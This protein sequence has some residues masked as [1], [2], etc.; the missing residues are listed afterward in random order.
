MALRELVTYLRY[1]VDNSGLKQYVKEADKAADDVSKA[2]K[3]TQPT[4]GGATPRVGPQG[5]KIVN[6]PGQ[7]PGFFDT[8]PGKTPRFIPLNTTVPG[9]TPG[10]S[11]FSIPNPNQVALAE[12]GAQ[13]QKMRDAEREA[14]A[15][16][17][18]QQQI[19]MAERSAQRQAARQAEVNAR[20]Q[21]RAEERERRNTA[22]AEATAART[23]A[24]QEAAAARVAERERRGAVAGGGGAARGFFGGIGGIVGPALAAIGIHEITHIADEWGTVNARIGL[25]TKNATEQKDVLDQI[26]QISLRTR[27]SYGE[28]ANLIFNMRQATEHAG[29]SMAD[30]LS[31]AENFNKALIIGGGTAANN[32]R[33]IY[34]LNHALEIG[35]LGGMQ[36][37]SL[38]MEAP[39]FIRTLSQQLAGGDAEKLNEMA[40]G[41]LLKTK[42]IVDALNKASDDLSKKFQKMPL[43]IGQAVTV[44]G[45]MFGKLISDIGQASGAFND[46]SHGIVWAAETFIGTIRGIADVVGGFAPFIRLLEILV[47]AFVGTK[48]I[49]GLNAIAKAFEA[50][51][52]AAALAEAPF[53]IIFG[54]LVA[55]ALVV[56]DVVGFLNGKKS[57][58]GSIFDAAAKQ[59]QKLQDAWPSVEAALMSG[60]EKVGKFIDTWLVQPLKDAFGWLEQLGQK[61]GI[62]STSDTKDPSAGPLAVPGFFAR[63]AMGV[64]S[65][66]SG[67]FNLPGMGSGTTMTPDG[68][69]I[70]LQQNINTADN[71][72]AIGN[73]AARGVERGA[74]AGSAARSMGNSYPNTEAK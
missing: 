29:V 12:R 32:R 58:T 28:T 37:R 70:H 66:L 54:L 2:V 56:E 43:T 39:I 27:Q 47:G 68:V 62:F 44:A 9:V 63:G 50:G 3:K 4:P 67:S 72:N 18:A 34:E 42:L 26:Y 53:V 59:M 40:K 1:K 38:R 33:A 48:L 5:Q 15:E 17:R 25:V 51:G 19:A 8:S 10:A 21:A 65:A 73:G 7:G 41:G 22:R 57:V 13:R 30:T 6:I 46:L 49:L 69:V 31:A 23:T 14:N 61:V 45:N 74:R 36:L 24:R 64:N 60:F 11:G 16:A 52:I 55:I 35:H 20:S 71:P